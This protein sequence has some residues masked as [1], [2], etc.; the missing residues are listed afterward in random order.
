MFLQTFH[1]ET[2]TKEHYLV[3]MRCWHLLHPWYPFRKS[4]KINWSPL[5][6][7][8]H[9]LLPPFKILLVISD[10]VFDLLPPS[11]L[12]TW[13]L[14]NRNVTSVLIALVRLFGIEKWVGGG[15]NNYCSFHP[16]TRIFWAAFLLS[17]A[18]GAFFIAWQFV[19]V[20]PGH[21]QL[22]TAICI[23]LVSHTK[24]WIFGWEG[25]NVIVYIFSVIINWKFQLTC[26]DPICVYKVLNKI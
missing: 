26:N 1:F 16:I 12:L 6:S 18:K 20:V 24:T 2:A 25:L 10:F 13:F 5:L 4:F 19:I 3:V 7:I 21:V 22:L 17:T 23:Y 9:L 14:L 11:L 15:N 8:A